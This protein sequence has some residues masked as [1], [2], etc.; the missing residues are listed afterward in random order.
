MSLCYS[1]PSCH[2][3]PHIP[4]P[5]PLESVHPTN[6][7][8]TDSVQQNA[9]QIQRYANT[10]STSPLSKEAS[11]HNANTV[12]LRHAPASTP[13]SNFQ[14]DYRSERENG[15]HTRVTQSSLILSPG[16]AN[17]RRR[18]S[19]LPMGLA[20]TITPRHPLYTLP[21]SMP[22]TA[23]SAPCR[24]QCAT[25]PPNRLAATNYPYLHRC[26]LALAGTRTP[27]RPPSA[28]PIATDPPPRR[29][30]AFRFS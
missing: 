26:P 28:S 8:S 23:T 7:L 17:R 11:Q 6:L 4:K 24:E 20:V 10:G 18:G 15:A 19:A 30:R 12:T 5:L 13:Q 1:K 27:R 25:T 9:T 16:L 14:F 22:L 21:P 29:Q 3:T 2:I